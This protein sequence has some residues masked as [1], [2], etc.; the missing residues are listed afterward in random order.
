MSVFQEAEILNT[1]I[2]TGKTVAV[3]VKVVSVEEDG[4]V[5]DL[6][7]AVECRS[8]DE[9][10]IKPARLKALEVPGLEHPDTST[11]LHAD[12]LRPGIYTPGPSV[13][14]RR[15]QNLPQPPALIFYVLSLHKRESRFQRVDERAPRPHSRVTRS[16]VRGSSGEVQ[17]LA[18]GQQNLP[19]RRSHTAAPGSPVDG[20][21]MTLSW[22]GLETKVASED[23]ARGSGQPTSLGPG[24]AGARARGHRQ[25]LALLRGP[26]C[27]GALSCPLGSPTLA[28]RHS[29][30]RDSGR[31][32]EPVCWASPRGPGGSPALGAQA[33]ALRLRSSPLGPAV[34]PWLSAT[35]AVHLPSSISQGHPGYSGG[36]QD[37]VEY[38]AHPAPSGASAAS[39]CLARPHG[40][41]GCVQSLG[42]AIQLP[43]P[44]PLEW[45]GISSR[46][47]GWTWHP[48]TQAHAAPEGGARGDP[49]G[50]GWARAQGLSHCGPRWP[51]DALTPTP[52]PQVSDRCDYVFV[53][54]KEVKGKA[55]VVV[56]FT[57]QHLSGALE[58]TVWAPR[59]PLQ[60]DVS[61]TELSQVKGWR[62][63]IVSSKRW[64]RRGPRAA[65]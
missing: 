5:T 31:Q 34:T 56:D 44:G 17:G 27:K 46:G 39:S 24:V 49:E 63:P 52:L 9:D 33:L 30:L 45:Q 51:L 8:S 12:V 20:P 62:V 6:P 29:Q 53:N 1:A 4:T 40:Q 13:L 23:M 37:D 11:Y 2:L 15:L 16:C 10:V 59:L 58:M 41:D 7:R 36:R 3:P 18:A 35:T 57:Y 38:S 61:D 22:V 60:I 47:A 14:G 42:T 32:A 55:G 26:G 54:G 28:D 21:A 19:S 48:A 65:A 64:V 50:H 25:S 43:L